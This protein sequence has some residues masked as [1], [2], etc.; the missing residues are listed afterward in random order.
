MLW[1]FT[2]KVS[3]ELW[4]SSTCLCL[5]GLR[6]VP[7][8]ALILWLVHQLAHRPRAGPSCMCNLPLRFS[9]FSRRGHHR[10]GAQLACKLKAEGTSLNCQ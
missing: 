4:V 5:C 2:W 10:V 9:L 3:R 1:L 8:A 7:V 6:C